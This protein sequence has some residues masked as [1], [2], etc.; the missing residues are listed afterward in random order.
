MSK[1]EQKKIKAMAYNTEKLR[2]LTVHNF[3]LSDSLSFIQGSLSDLVNN[4]ASGKGKFNVLNQ[5]RIAKT[6]RERQL[7]LRKGIKYAKCMINTSCMNNTSNSTFLGVFPYDYAESIEKLEQCKQLPR[8]EDFYNRLTDS[9]ISDQDFDHAK[10]VFK[11]FRCK[12]MLDYMTL[13][14]ETDTYLLADVFINFRTTMM[15]KFGLD[16]A[17]FVSLPSYGFQSMLKLTKVTL[18]YI[19]D[20]DVYL[21]ISQ[22]I[23]GGLSFVGNRYVSARNESTGKEDRSILYYDANNLYGYAQCQF[24]PTR[25]FRFESVSK[26]LVQKILT[27]SSNSPKGYILECDLR[28]PAKLHAKHRNFPLCPEKMEITPSMLSSYQL[29][30]HS[31][32]GTKPKPSSKLVSTFRDREKYV[33]HYE[34]LKLYLKLG[35]KLIKVHRILSFDQ[36]PF[37]KKFIDFC[38]QMRQKATSSLEKN[39]FKLIS[40][41][42]YGKT[43]E[44]PTKYLNV[45]FVTER[46]KLKQ[47]LTDPYFHSFK[48]LSKSL[49]LVFTRNKK[50]VIRQPYAVGFTILEL[51]KQCMLHST[52]KFNQHLGKKS[53]WCVSQT[54]ILSFFRCL[55]AKIRTR[56]SLTSWMHQTLI[57]R[58]NF[59][60]RAENRHLDISKVKLEAQKSKNS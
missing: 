34:N 32:L 43:I 54:L 31:T 10:K 42:C 4:L 15:D 22:N 13:Y 26:E 9:H 30:C 49:V 2:N 51:S 58:M 27:T 14:M 25:N 56:K 1:G 5:M 17:H 45:T 19:Y 3:K 16:P 57:Q 8:K 35:M 23:R 6:E 11:T 28:Y 38:T 37:L 12:N 50:A 46:K 21:F 48:I 18:D 33:I 53:A 20:M 29:K 55:L 36:A 41:S 40:N 39:F 24:L 44:N 7:L 47:L 52:I 60:T 59:L